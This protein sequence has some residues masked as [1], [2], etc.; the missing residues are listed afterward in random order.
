[1]KI[2]ELYC[3]TKSIGKVAK[4]RG[5]QVYSVD[6][7]VIHEPDLIADILK[8]DL[9]KLPWVPDVVWASPPCTTF[10]VASMGKHWTGG[11]RAYIPK[12]KAAI[13]GLKMMARTK[14][15]ILKL[16]PKLWF[17]EN[18]VGVM[19]KVIGLSQYQHTVSY[20]QYGDTRKKPTDIWT[21]AKW[22]NKPMCKNGAPCHEAAPRGSK[23]G[24]QGLAGAIERG[25]IPRQLCLEIIEACEKQL[26]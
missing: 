7:D 8:L 25:V 16:K 18:P 11:S 3:G 15:I 24:T 14:G 9:S 23:T 6:I 21:N 22:N 17:I 2:L 4:E 26:A 1:M 12:T 20:C 5:H 13:H 19:R 10:S